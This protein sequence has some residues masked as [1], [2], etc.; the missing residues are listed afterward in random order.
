MLK[1]INSITEGSE[2][3]GWIPENLNEGHLDQLFWLMAGLHVLN[4]LAFTYCAMRYKGKIA[5]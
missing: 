5:T 4:L 3:H 2:S 1:F